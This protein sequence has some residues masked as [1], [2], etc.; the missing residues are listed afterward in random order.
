ME[1]QELMN[2]IGTNRKA[3]RRSAGITQAQLAEAA[4]IST[5]LIANIILLLL[6]G[7]PSEYVQVRTADSRFSGWISCH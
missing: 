3:R 2:L 4:D 7:L 1:K 6:Q 5:P